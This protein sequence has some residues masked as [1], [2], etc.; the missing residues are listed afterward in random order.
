[1]RILIGIVL[2]LASTHLEAQ[3]VWMYSEE[4]RY[5]SQRDPGIVIFQD[6]SEL[7]VAWG[8]A[9]QL[10][11]EESDKWPKSKRLLIA[12]RPEDG[13]V[14]LDPD[15][16]KL[17]SVLEISNQP[18]DRIVDICL[19]TGLSTRGMVECFGMGLS[20]WDREL[21]RLY[22]HLMRSSNSDL[23]RKI[24]T[25]QRAWVRF[26]DATGSA[27]GDV[28]TGGTVAL[29]ERAME[30]LSLTKQQAERLQRF[31]AECDDCLTRE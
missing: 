5:E 7:R 21:N 13:T 3:E 28:Y 30:G 12:Y 14:L 22:G 2:V 25:A 1:M 9:G 10:T 17:V 16:G 19:E 6:G 15:S 24:Q 26:R 27:I 8:I 20:L 23:T 31:L 29:V 18:I 4:V 11:W